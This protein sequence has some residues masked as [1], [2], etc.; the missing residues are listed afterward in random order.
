MKDYVMK[1]TK[2][3]SG[4]HKGQYMGEHGVIYNEDYARRLA[5]ELFT[6]TKNKAVKKSTKRT[7]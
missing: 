7:K 5:P 3:E 4:P 1:L 2:I 6:T